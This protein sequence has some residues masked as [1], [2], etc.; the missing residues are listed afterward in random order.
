MGKIAFVFAGQ[1]AQYPGMGRE[2][3]QCSRAAAEIFQKVDALRPGTSEQCFSGTEEELKETKNTQPCLFAVELAAAAALAERGLKADMAAGFSLGEIGALTYTGAVDFATGFHLVCRRGE[4]M[5][6]AAEEQPTAMAAVLKLSNEDVEGLCAQFD[7]VYPVNYNCPG[8]V[9]VACAQAQLAPFSAAVKA[10]GGRALPL[11]VRGGFHS[12]FMASA[13]QGFAGVLAECQVGRPEIPLY[14]NCTG[15]VYAGD[16]KELLAR[17]I[18]SPVRW[19]TIV[20]N[21]I[22]AGA[23]TFL[24]LGPGKTLCGLIGKIDKR[25]KTYALSTREDLETIL[26][27]VAGC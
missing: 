14:S 8:Q 3:A 21:M 26:R 18:A 6:A 5:Q 7:Q 25:V 10:A 23:D 19:E 1:G 20:R 16:P 11:K 12:P 27:E 13:A 15:R 17:Q 2:L 24:E 4:L 22:A 9:S